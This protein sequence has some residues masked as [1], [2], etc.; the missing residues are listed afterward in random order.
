[1]GGGGTDLPSYYRQFGGFL[2]AATID[3]YIHVTVNR[4]F[5]EN[6]RLSYSQTEIVD[7][8]EDV[9]HRIFREAMRSTNIR[10][11]VEL[12][13][14][15]DVP[16][17]CGLG[18]SSTFTVALL[19][20]LFAYQRKYF[21][22]Q[23][24]AEAACRLEIEVL[25]QRIGK[26]DQYAAAFGG[27]NCYWF[28]PDDS[29]VVEKVNIGEEKLHDLQNNIVLFHLGQERSASEILA[30]QSDQSAQGD[31][32]TLDRLHKIKDIG[33]QTRKIFEHGEIDDFG[34]I[35]HE[36]WM[37]KKKLSAAVSNPRMDEVYE[38]ARKSG[39]LGGK[40]VGAGG[41]GFFLFYCPSR[42]TILVSA[43]EKMGL[44]PMWFNFEASGAK[45]VYQH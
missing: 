14:V 38:A 22:P 12:V 19:N 27:F 43:M 31:K 3:K 39:A 28:N 4:R 26:Q 37:T 16:S 23:E 20:G 13:S 5:S 29:V 44:K 45:I 11:Q 33:L 24:L 2:M 34:E 36:H 10:S 35:L 8:V 25:E 1:M 40:I 15:A 7:R 21:H 30:K 42:K 6:I 18:T 32:A 17:N 9:Q 41:G